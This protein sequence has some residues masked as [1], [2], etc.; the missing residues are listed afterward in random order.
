MPTWNKN[1]RK[2][3]SSFPFASKIFSAFPI[4]SKPWPFRHFEISLP[5]LT[6][7]INAFTVGVC[8]LAVQFGLT[9]LMVVQ[10]WSVPEQQNLPLIINSTETEYNL[11]VDVC[12]MDTNDPLYNIDLMI[13]TFFT[14]L[15]WIIGLPHS[16]VTNLWHFLCTNSLQLMHL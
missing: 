1:R 9:G 13:T 8:Y 5:F 12:I 7:D 11:M 6:N 2:N 14:A 10:A 4:H 16:T 3:F 15:T